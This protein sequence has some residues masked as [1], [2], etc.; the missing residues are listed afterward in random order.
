MRLSSGLLGVLA[1]GGIIAA[2]D[3]SVSATAEPHANVEADQGLTPEQALEVCTAYRTSDCNFLDRCS[4]KEGTFSGAFANKEDCIRLGI[5]TCT[6]TLQRSGYDYEALRAGAESC[7]NERESAACDQPPRCDVPG[8]RAV[9]SSCAVN[10]QCASMFCSYAPNADCGKCAE[11]ERPAAAPSS[12][13]AHKDCPSGQRCQQGECGVLA[14]PHGQ[15]CGEEYDGVDQGDCPK[16]FVC[17]NTDDDPFA[18]PVCFE[19]RRVALV[20]DGCLAG[21]IDL[22]THT[23]ATCAEGACTFGGPPDEGYEDQVK[24]NAA[25]KCVAYVSAGDPCGPSWEGPACPAGYTCDTTTKTCTEVPV[26]DCR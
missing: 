20:G 5:Q 6:E 13:T 2:C 25:S 15:P 18:Q 24:R 4:V 21:A 19:L 12:C 23:I 22:A 17:S 10:G 3:T 14:N 8:T 26:L 7:A 9:G 16:G 1:I 11:P